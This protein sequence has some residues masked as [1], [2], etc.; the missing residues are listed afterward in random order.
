MTSIEAGRDLV[1]QIDELLLQI[2][3]ATY[4]QALPIFNGSSMGQHFRHILNFYECVLQ[5][6]RGTTIDYALR[7]RDIR[8]E[9][10]PSYAR[11]AYTR[12][13]AQLEELQ[14][15]Q[16]IHVLGDFHAGS[17]QRQPVPSSVGRELLYAFDHAV[18]HLAIIRIGLRTLDIS[19][20][21][22]DNVGVAPST[23]RHREQ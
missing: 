4:G 18:H 8:I 16:A 9:T 17:E 3:T 15:T 6:S 2:P 20:S 19:V 1:R 7:E 13:L 14:E 22:D 11:S 5:S 12:M 21:V 23:V 10:D